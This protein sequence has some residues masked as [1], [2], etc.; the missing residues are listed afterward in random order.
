M[1]SQRSKAFFRVDL[2]SCCHALH[3][4]LLP[5]WK[6]RV[7]ALQLGLSLTEVVLELCCGNAASQAGLFLPVLCQGA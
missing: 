2:K 4:R 5:T 3:L 1:S 7:L 6:M